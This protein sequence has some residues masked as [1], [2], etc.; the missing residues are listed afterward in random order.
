MQKEFQTFDVLGIPI[1]AV[2]LQIASDALLR[3]SL[4]DRGRYVGAREVASVMAM[5]DD[6]KLLAVANGAA[7]NLP[8][9]MPMVWIG[10]RRGFDVERASGPDF[11]FKMLAE[12]P[13]NGLKHYLFGGKEGV[14]EKL[15]EQLSPDVR[16]RI[17]GTFCPPFRAMTTE[18]T[19]VAIQMIRESGADVVWVG[20]SSPKQDV[21]MA[22]N[23]KQLPVTMVGVGAAFD[24]LSGA[25]PRAPLWMQRSG[26][27]S[28]F[29]LLTDFRRLWRRYLILAPK[30]VLKMLTTR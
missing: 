12:S 18:E 25:V 11:M 19:S 4:D 17:V 9:G 1:S 29:R 26:L 15:V 8:D 5:H 21:W 10:K 2:N 20:M 23:H 28:V 30:F 24:F 3:W 27:E 16:S 6:P 22:E 14:A 7:M 13:E